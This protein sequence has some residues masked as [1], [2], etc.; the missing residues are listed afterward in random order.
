MSETPMRFS[1]IETPPFPDSAAREKRSQPFSIFLQGVR[2]NFYRSDG[3][4][5]RLRE[6]DELSGED[7]IPGFRCPVRDIFPP[8]QRATPVPSAPNGPN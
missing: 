4:V 7:V 8:S 6:S 1:V 2:P 5:S 3:S